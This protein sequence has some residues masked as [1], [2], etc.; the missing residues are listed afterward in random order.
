[1]EGNRKL[2][3]G[4]I[5]SLVLRFVI[6]DIKFVPFHIFPPRCTKLIALPVSSE[7]GSHAKE[8]LLLWCQRK[9]AA[10]EQVDISN[11]TKSWQ[12]GLALS[13]LPSSHLL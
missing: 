3:L 11:F 9:T 5:W 12:D 2:I 4:M 1:M 7:E 10:Y 6:A 13:V 8:G